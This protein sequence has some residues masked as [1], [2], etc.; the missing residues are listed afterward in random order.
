MKVAVITSNPKTKG[1]LAGLTAEAARGAEEAGAEVEEVRLADKNIGYCRFCM[2]CYR[3]AGSSTGRCVQEDDMASILEKLKEADGYIMVSPVS[4]G[5]A[6]ALFKTFFER[7]C[8]TA[9]RP[10]RIL[11][12]KGPPES[13]WTDKQRYAVT[14][15]TAGTMPTWLRALCNIA[16]RQMKELSKCAFNA[17][18]IGS[19]Y[20]GAVNVGGFKRSYTEGA[21]SLGRSLVEE[22][23]S[24]E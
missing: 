21:Y 8:Y 24:P 13:R 19:Q 9:G 12:I 7:C 2:T 18:V 14:V 23:A 20:A 11:W 22:I 10:G 5:H 15:V 17:R 1:A 4:S 6:N 16:T 3:D